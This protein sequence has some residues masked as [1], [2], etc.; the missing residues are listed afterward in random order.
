[1]K[2]PTRTDRRSLKQPRTVDHQ[3]LELVRGGSQSLPAPTIT[4]S[5]DWEA[6]V[7]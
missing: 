7:V 3:A 6:P 4:A 5:D 1:M 2:K